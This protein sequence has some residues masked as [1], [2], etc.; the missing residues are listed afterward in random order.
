MYM[1]QS[2]NR[3]RFTCLV[4]TIMVAR[5]YG[6]SGERQKLFDS[7][8]LFSENKNTFTSVTVTSLMET[9]KEHFL[10]LFLTKNK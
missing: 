10:F 1:Y 4:H 6:S 7:Q 2:R 9:M 8:L 3:K 5:V